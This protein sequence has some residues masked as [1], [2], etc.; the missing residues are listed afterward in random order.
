[1]HRMEQFERMLAYVACAFPFSA[2]APSSGSY[3]VTDRPR[4]S[5]PQ[6]VVRSWNGPDEVLEPLADEDE[7]GAAAA[8][9]RKDRCCS[10]GH[11]Q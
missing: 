1:L 5:W 9:M 3:R 4:R 7:V 11:A 8:A 10:R 2:S 6:V